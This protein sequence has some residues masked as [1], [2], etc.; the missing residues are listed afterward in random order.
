MKLMLSYLSRYKSL[1]FLALVLT[2]VSQVF[3]FLN[4]YFL[5]NYLID[6][7]AQKAQYFRENGLDD[8][9]FRG[10]GFGMLLIIAASTISWVAKSYQEYTVNVIIQK[11]G[12]SLY[13]D[14]QRHTFSLPYKDFENQVSGQVL[15]VLQ[16]ARSDSE[17]FITRFVHV[18]F[19]TAIGIIVVTIIAFQLSPWL[20]VVYLGGAALLCFFTHKISRKI[21]FIQKKILDESTAL[22]GSTTE[23]I[24]NIE[25]VKSLGLTNQEIDRLHNTTERILGN[26]IK[27][28][29]SLRSVGFVYGAFV[30]TLHQG[31]IFFLL[32][33]IFYDSITVGQL[34]MMQIYF[35]YIFGTLE[36]LGTVIAAYKEAEASLNNLT[37]ILN[38]PVETLPKNAEKIE[39]IESLRF[40]KVHFQHQS[41]TRPALA[42]VSFELKCGETIAIVGPSGSGKTT[43]V[44]LL[45]GLYTPNR[46]SIYYNDCNMRKIDFN[47][48][49]NQIGLVTQDTQ[50]FSGTIRENL[51]F[52]N[53]NATDEMIHD[54]LEKAACQ[55][56]LA[57][58]GQGL[59]TLIG[60]GGLKVSGGER[61]RLSIARALLRESSLLIFDEATSSLDSLTEEDI[62]ATMRRITNQKKYITVMIAHRLSTIMFAHRILVLE[63]G[64]IVETGNHASLLEEKGLYYA[65][66]RQQTSEQKEMA[67]A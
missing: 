1:V 23:S 44:K 15:S 28:L 7:F 52:V 51:L 65:M 21:K 46:G 4:P 9:F 25:L 13:Q 8:E 41:A 47:Q 3:N 36:E 17:K 24:R 62:A 49:R 56:L 27:K 61:Q 35:Y 12:A 57:R 34:L 42:D 63:R 66:W 2:V 32:L 19:S 20:P 43:L 33:F 18:L 64:R 58:A 54:V 50:L 55:D 5:G 11:F 14:V 53:K 30:H 48:L 37:E 67:I 59:E 45:A 60:E 6:P 31:I 29:K 16:R 26:E 40:E 22:A 38:K 10:V 39:S